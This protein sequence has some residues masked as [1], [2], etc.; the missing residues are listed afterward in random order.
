VLQGTKLS[1]HSN[2]SPLEVV[3]IVDGLSTSS[4]YDKIKKS[5]EINQL[6]DTRLYRHAK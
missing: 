3:Y 4:L 2:P 5:M 1:L 6:I